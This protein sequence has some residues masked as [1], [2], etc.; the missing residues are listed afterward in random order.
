M[1]DREEVENTF[2]FELEDGGVVQCINF[3][4][5]L[6]KKWAINKGHDMRPRCNSAHTGRKAPSKGHE[7]LRRCLAR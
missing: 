4:G 6:N 7:I 1:R 5:P 3:E 2:K